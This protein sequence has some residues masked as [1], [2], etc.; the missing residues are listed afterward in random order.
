MSNADDARAVSACATAR[1]RCA[2]AWRTLLAARPQRPPD[3]S[4]TSNAA[5][6]RNYLAEAAGDAESIGTQIRQS[7]AISGAVSVWRI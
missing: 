3:R 6:V 2:A 1:S 7:S 5:T 4:P